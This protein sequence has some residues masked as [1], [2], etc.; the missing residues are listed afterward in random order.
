MDQIIQDNVRIALAEDLG[1]GDI[2]AGLIAADQSARARI[3]VRESAILCGSAW[4]EEVFK[5]L[6]GGVKIQWHFADGD[7]LALDQEVCELQGPA[8]ILLSGERTALNFLQTLSGTATLTRRYVD[9]IEGTGTRLLDTRKTIPGLRAAQKYA[10]RCGGG[11]NHRMGLYDAVLI[12]ENHI[13]AAGSIITAVQKARQLQPRAPLVVE[14][15]SL[16]QIKEALTVDT[17]RLLLDNMAPATLCKA[18]QLTAKQAQLEAS[19]GITLSNIRSIADTGVDFISIG[20]LT[21]NLKAI[22]F[23][24]RFLD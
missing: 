22:D 15:E 13:H 6:G 11:Y 14:V 17:P 8:R 23:S 7:T 1:S 20:D 2:T 5:Q 19:G 3:V 9:A 18:V 12:K 21:K 10:V 16:E 4:F 24:M